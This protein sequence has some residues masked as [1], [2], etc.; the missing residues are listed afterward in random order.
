MTDFSSVTRLLNHLEF[1]YRPG[2]QRLVLDLFAL[3]GIQ[4]GGT[5][6]FLVGSIDAATPNHVDNIIAESEAVPEQLA[7]DSAL[8]TALQTEPLASAYS[9]YRER[10]IANPQQGTHA[11]IRFTTL[12]EWQATVDRFADLDAVAPSLAGRVRFD[13]AIVP[14]HPKSYS[15]Y[16]YQAFVWTDVIAT[17]S[18]A[19]GQKFELQYFDFAG[20][21]DS[22]G[23]VRGTRRTARDTRRSACRAD[24]R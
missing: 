6:T 2:E 3:L 5:K 12:E 8:A 23:T 10:L 13:D 20:Y 7:L 18:L 11:G 16:L 17:G 9:A 24:R 19:F 4:P 14:G 22:E 21:A 15:P 1:V